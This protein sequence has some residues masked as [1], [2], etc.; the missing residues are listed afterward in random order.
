MQHEGMV[1]ALEE[2]RRIL[3]PAGTLIDMHPVPEPEAVEVHQG[4]KIDLVGYWSVP[5]WLID[6]RVAD[7]ALAEVTRRGLFSAEREAVFDS[8][9]HYDSVSE[10]LTDLKEVMGR[11]I[12]DAQVA[13]EALPDLEAL[14]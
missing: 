3:R 9:T 5:E 7:D 8:L 2:I 1:H 4:G 13:D 12:K 6:E 10:M 11:F 14:A